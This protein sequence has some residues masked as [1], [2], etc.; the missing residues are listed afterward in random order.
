MHAAFLRRITVRLL[1]CRHLSVLMHL[2]LKVHILRLKFGIGRVLLQ[3][4]L[5][6]QFH[7]LVST[8]K[9]LFDDVGY[10]ESVVQ[11]CLTFEIEMLLPVSVSLRAMTVLFLSSWYC[12][13]LESASTFYELF[14]R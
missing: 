1:L 7:I 4:G 3:Q 12:C 13:L 11:S 5:P 6:E 8:S 2:F 10:L 9:L 14:I